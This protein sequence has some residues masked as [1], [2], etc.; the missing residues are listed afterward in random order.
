MS[1]VHLHNHSYF[2]M[3]DG[4]GGPQA[5]ARRARELGMPAL[6]LTDHGNLY[7]A[8]EFY[9]ACEKEGIKPILGVDLYVCDDM[10]DKTRSAHER[11]NL[12]VLA[13]NNTGWKNL[14]QLVTKAHLEGFYYK[15]RVDKNLLKQH[16]EG[17]IALSGCLLGEIPQA[18]KNNHPERARELLQE[19]QD[20][21]GN[22]HF[23]IELSHHPGVPEHD[24]VQKAL[25]QL[26]RDT[27]TPIVA[28]QNTHYVDKADAPFQDVLLAVQTGT[29]F[30]DADR[31]TM[32]KDDFSLRSTEDMQK[33]FA[34]TP[35]AIENT[36]N[37]ANK[38][39][40]ELELGK[41]Q[42]PP[43]PLPKGETNESYLKKLT[44]K[45]LTS[46][47]A[48]AEIA[49]ATEQL[50]FELDVIARTGFS[51][52][53]LIVADIVNW[54]KDQGIVV[55]PGRGSAAGSIIA[56]LLRITDVDPI[57]YHLLFERFMNPD[58]ISMP[59]IDLD[60][61]DTR[62]DEVIEYI[63]K[64]YGREQVAQ[65]ITFGTM[66]ARAAIRD[67]GR[68]LGLPYGFCDEVAK[69]VP[70][71]PGW[72]LEKARE[73]VPEL[74][75]RWENDPDAAR[76]LEAA[77]HL[78]GVVRH[79]STHACGLVI[80][81]RPL[82]ETLPLQYSTT[83]AGEEKA[84]VTQFN[85]P[86]VEA[87]G[88]LKM[89]I[90][91]LSNL[92]IIEETVGRIKDTTGEEIDI[93]N[94]P[95]DDKL[96]YRQ[97]AR[98]HTVGVFQLESQG[99]TK[100]LKELKPT[101]FEDLVTMIALYRPG[102][103]EQIPSYIRRKHGKEQ[104]TYP[105]P[106][107]EPYLKNTN[108]IMIYQ[109]QLMQMSRAMA[110]FTPG[111]ADTLRKA[112]GKKIH[113]LLAEQKEKF[114]EGVVK[115][116][117]SERLA[118]QLW[119]LVLPFANYGFNRSHAV[120]YA[121]VAYQTAYLKAHYP[122]AFMTSLLNSDAKNIDRMT[123][124]IAAAKNENIEVLP[125]DINASGAQF[126]MTDDKHI[127]FGL[128]AIKNVGHNVVSSLVAERDAGGPFTSLTN[129]LERADG[130]VLNKKS[131]EALIKTGAVDD[132]GERM[133][134]LENMDTL[135]SYLR[136][137]DQA[138]SGKQESL[139]GLM[140]ESALPELKLAAAEPAKK[141]EKLQWEK[142]LLGLYVSGHPLDDYAEGASRG[143]CIRDAKAKR[144]RT[145]V[146]VTGLLANVKRIMTKNGD[147]M[148]FLTLEDTNDQIEGVMF[149]RTLQQYGG[150]LEANTCVLVEG[151]IQLRNGEHNLICDK[152]EILES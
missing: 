134:L 25:L 115:K 17:L 128:G 54:A 124:L 77:H 129:F 34:D 56:Y 40:L 92:S 61:A 99:M 16:A 79:A 111:E 81:A 14:L 114:I 135:L 84:L 73:A 47:Y 152:V 59:D 142:E 28:A 8:I 102:S 42:L 6:A 89:D 22:E 35:E 13:Q 101:E 132:F 38:I 139:F 26:A 149:P 120:C 98:G 39:T 97:L 46:R 55:G 24:N 64:T 49:A 58:R 104:I 76:V 31:L 123:F 66:A 148:A 32:H 127:R 4:L 103:M 87:L 48:D 110:D 93:T 107:L 23:Y 10:Q 119:E 143:D 138:R 106:L 43:Y 125:P 21:F 144:K 118:N 3:L 15:P 126:E 133:E 141:A 41:T 2:S 18:L 80:G 57:K 147:P 96:S 67:A 90:L 116:T 88:L 150:Q 86:A 63:M 72:T 60:F 19:Y 151:K 75:E 74:K 109:E 140:E 12:V 53:F 136:A 130:S 145:T 95:L 29:Q 91:G 121:A 70:F 33:L 62:R 69:L 1:F 7:G 68:A 83:G 50:D 65:I 113:K 37:I 20:I 71:G 27:Q 9:Q 36:V 11:Y 94:L 108:G 51:S 122:T 30:D 78:E 45:A 100:Y 5:L 105:H 131:L 117:K 146:R 112:V 137:S 44:H 52:Y 85:G 82:P